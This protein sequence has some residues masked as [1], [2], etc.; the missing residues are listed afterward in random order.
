MI[1][2][3]QQPYFTEFNSRRRMVFDGRF[4]APINSYRAYRF[5][6]TGTPATQPAVAATGGKRT[7]V[8]A[9]W[10]GSNLV[11]TWRVLGGSSPQSLRPV[12][13]AGITGFET[14]ISTRAERY[15]E[16]QA[17]DSKGRTLKT[18]ALVRV[19]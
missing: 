10:N 1:G 12:G 9:S 17:L 15:I 18:S 4:I 3:G 2:W 11:K 16:A 7:T 5:R 13:Q 14:R 8:Y 6:W 19:R